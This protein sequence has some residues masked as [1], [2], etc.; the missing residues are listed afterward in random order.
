MPGVKIVTW[1]IQTLGQNA[2]DDSFE[3]LD[4]N[5][6]RTLPAHHRAMLKVRLLQF[7][8]F[9]YLNDA[10]TSG[11]LFVRLAE[12]SG[13]QLQREIDTI[14]AIDVSSAVIQVPIMGVPITSTDKANAIELLQRLR[15]GN[16]TT[17]N[18]SKLAAIARILQIIQFDILIV[19]EL[20]NSVR[21]VEV[22]EELCQ[23]LL[24]EHY[25]PY[26]SRQSGLERYGFIVKSDP[27][28]SPVFLANSAPAIGPL[29][30]GVGDDA[31]VPINGVL[32]NLDNYNF[33]IDPTQATYNGE[34]PLVDLHGMNDVGPGLIRD[35][36]GNNRYVLKRLEDSITPDHHFRHP[37][38]ALFKLC[39]VLVPIIVCHTKSGQ[40]G[41]TR[42]Q[43]KRIKGLHI[44]QKYMLGPPASKT[45]RI[46]GV[47]TAV[48]NIVITGDFNLDFQRFII[49]QPL[50]NFYNTRTNRSN[51][52]AARFY[53]H[54]SSAQWESPL[55]AACEAIRNDAM[56]AAVV[57]LINNNVANG[58][59]RNIDCL[60][61]LRLNAAVRHQKTIYAQTS[62]VRGAGGR[63]DWSPQFQ[64]L[65]TP[66]TPNFNNIN[67][68]TT[69][70]FDNL[71][72]GGQQIRS[73][74][75]VAQTPEVRDFSN[76]VYNTFVDGDSCPANKVY[77]GKLL[78][79]EYYSS[80][81]DVYLFLFLHTSVVKFLNLEDRTNFVNKIPAANRPA[82]PIAA[83][84]VT[85][86]EKVV[87]ARL[88]S[89]HLPVSIH[90]EIV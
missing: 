61:S 54:L 78:L 65:F 37:C 25:I 84:E 19:V 43:M 75:N 82:L 17:N 56:N 11:M 73:N 79:D 66:G 15:N 74:Q 4:Q 30:P 21:A 34:F 62:F 7:F 63:M 35:R 59:W 88:L 87:V 41:G 47:L 26:V 48:E 39:D 67:L 22:L 50:I 13:A 14:T 77:L 86:W 72:Y 32:R 68:K 12:L 55:V 51:N 5:I 9:D 28:I 60:P 2:R 16:A 33:T 70:S 85:E 83:V 58:P 38:M 10:R 40:G 27:N 64:A 20:R 49:P 18:R 24:P 31:R 36:D 23:L 69:A 6:Q 8:S 45:L 90:L 76:H 42:F 81:K 89:D 3:S 46:D 57:S 53:E 52:L 29:P 1:N 44:C 71:F 80:T